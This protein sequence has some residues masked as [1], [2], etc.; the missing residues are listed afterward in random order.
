MKYNQNQIQ[1]IRDLHNRYLDN[2]LKLDFDKLS[3]NQMSFIRCV[4]VSS[5]MS[6][7]K[8]KSHNDI[9]LSPIKNC[10]IQVSTKDQL[11]MMS[12]DELAALGLSRI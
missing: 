10:S 5:I 11:A 9:M 6:M 8:T 2:L 7:K 3:Y 4:S 1:A 12:D